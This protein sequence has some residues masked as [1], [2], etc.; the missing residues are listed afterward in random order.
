MKYQYS[1]ETKTF[2]LQKALQSGAVVT[3]STA[4]K[5]FGIKNLSA[6][7]SRIK[8]NGYVVA[9]NTR[10][11]NNGVTVTEYALG[12][13]NREMIA[14]AYKAKALGLSV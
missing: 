9:K 3:A 13:A 12:K 10:K 8:Q 11:A 1:K 14:L 4:A 5:M 2:K 6:E 7:I